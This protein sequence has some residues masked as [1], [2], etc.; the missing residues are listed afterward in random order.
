MG[1]QQPPSRRRRRLHAVII[2]VRTVHTVPRVSFVSA[3]IRGTRDGN[4]SRAR[5]ASAHNAIPLVTDNSTAI[6]ERS[7]PMSPLP[8]SFFF[9]P[10]FPI[11]STP[12]PFFTLPHE[13]IATMTIRADTFPHI[14]LIP[15]ALRLYLLTAARRSSTVRVCAKFYSNVNFDDHAESIIF[16]D[17]EET[18]FVQNLTACKAG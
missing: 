15:S 5:G 10:F 16:C 9:P 4:E 13:L 18:D 6:P 7:L 12:S 11:S 1:A 2:V 3:A 8:L 17:I 14:V